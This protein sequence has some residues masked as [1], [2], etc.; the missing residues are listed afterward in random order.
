MRDLS[1]SPKRLIAMAV[2][3]ILLIG[4]CAAPGTTT[5][6]TQT[7]APAIVTPTAAA[8]PT[9]G[10]AASGTPVATTAGTPTAASEAPSVTT[11]AVSSAAPSLSNEPVT[12]AML[13]YQSSANAALGTAIDG[14]ITGFTTAHPNVTINRTHTTFAD[15]LPKQQL[16]MSGPNPCDICDIAVNYTAAAKLAQAG[17]LANLDP[18]AA[19]Y[20]WKQK[21]SPFLWSQSQYGPPLT[22]GPVYGIFLTEDIVGV[23]Y[24]KDKLSALGLS[25]PTTFDEF[26]TD[27]ATIKAAGQR[28][29]M[30]GNLDKWPAIHVF[31]QID[32]ASCDKTDLRNYVY[33]L[34]STAFDKPCHV[35]AAQTFVDWLKAGYFGSA[36]PN[37]LGMDDA[38]NNFIKGQSVFYVDGTWDTKSIDDGLGAK[39]GF[40]NIPAPADGSVP[41]AVLGGLGQTL[42]VHGKSANPNIGAAFLD[43]LISDQAAKAYLDAG[44]VPGFAFKTTETFST[45]REDVLAAIA[46]AN[47]SDSLV[48]YLD[49]PTP[50]MYDV[51]TAAL[52]DL[53]AGKQ[54]PAQ[55]VATVQADYAKGP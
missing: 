34:A 51:I 20:G 15:L 1:S 13:D 40:F 54:T 38:R 5:A 16:I 36:D 21:Y 28:P 9:A 30:F 29:I 43:S 11:A 32:N 49:G 6:P 44:A 12:L 10:L 31:E 26:V 7:A 18:Y 55:F 41:F 24:N 47:E 48:G 27:L 42:T 53:M 39:V 8:V 37:A 22:T 23:F 25:L 50:R 17:L 19:Q 52:Q 2:S 33:R 14:L 3:I 45:L 46:K 4:A 35:N